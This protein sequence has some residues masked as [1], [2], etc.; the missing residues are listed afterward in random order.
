VASERAHNPLKLWSAPCLKVFVLLGRGPH[1]RLGLAATLT[2]L[3][4]AQ[5]LLS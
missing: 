4:L 5:V 2:G 1:Q 3:P